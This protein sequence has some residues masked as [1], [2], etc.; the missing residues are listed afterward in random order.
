MQRSS[1]VIAVV[2]LVLPWHG[3]RR[4]HRSTT[5]PVAFGAASRALVTDDYCTTLDP[6]PDGRTVVTGRTEAQPE[7]VSAQY[8]VNGTLDPTFGSAVAWSDRS[9]SRWTA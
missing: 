3:W 9:M 2:V 8:K 6:M 4:R 7:M 1:R 5:D